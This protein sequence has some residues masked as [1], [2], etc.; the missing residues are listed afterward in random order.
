MRGFCFLDTAYI[1]SRGGWMLCDDS[2]V[3]QCDP[4]QVVVSAFPCSYSKTYG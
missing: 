3:K 4:K 2:S 1:A